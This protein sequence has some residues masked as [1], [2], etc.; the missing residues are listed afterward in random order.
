MAR[1]SNV[2]H[3]PRL[4]LRT[5]TVAD[6][7]RWEE[8]CQPFE[9]ARNTLRMPHPYP[10]G[11]AEEHIRKMDEAQARGE[12]VRFGI[13]EGDRAGPGEIIGM[14]GLHI[15]APHHHAE[16]GY[17]IGMPYWGRGYATEAAAAVVDHGFEALNLQRIHAGYYTR[18]PA[19]GR[20]LEK[21][22]FKP[23]GMRER[24]YLRFGEW[25][26]C[27]LMRIFREEWQAAR[28]GTQR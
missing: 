21:L 7:P 23:E 14:I 8:L 1:M 6:A 26:D 5:P 22:G 25:V 16:L 20:I 12:A 15:D 17:S 13:F 28:A 3:T 4:L 27:V 18:N 2:L 24:M 9:M 19:S 11:A 10:K